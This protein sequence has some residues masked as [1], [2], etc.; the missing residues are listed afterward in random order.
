MLL[1][2]CS[3]LWLADDQDQL[4]DTAKLLISRHADALFISAISSWEIT[5]KHQKGRLHLPLRPDE[6]IET[7]L[8]NHGICAI[9]ISNQIAVQSALLPF[10]HQDPC[11]RI[12]IA[13]AQLHDLTV[14]S[15]DEEFYKYSGLKIDW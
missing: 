14:I 2:S 9:P 15:P 10:H 5:L 7:A 8:T 6:W 4:S 13:T 12:I 3:L 11:D 1:D